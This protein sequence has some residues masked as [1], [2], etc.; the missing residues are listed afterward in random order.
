MSKSFKFTLLFFLLLI[1]STYVPKNQ[2]EKKSL[3]DSLYFSKL[4]GD[5]FPLFT[6]VKTKKGIKDIR[7]EIINSLSIN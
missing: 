3:A 6:S 2:N 1:F 5:N 7:K 4:A